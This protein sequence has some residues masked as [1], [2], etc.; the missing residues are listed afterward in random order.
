[1]KTYFNTTLALMLIFLTSNANAYEIS[2]VNEFSIFQYLEEVYEI[3]NPVVRLKKIKS[4]INKVEDF[5]LKIKILRKNA[6]YWSLNSEWKICY[7]AWYIAENQDFK[8]A[9]DLLL[10]IDNKNNLDDNCRIFLASMAR[11][12]NS[13]FV[14]SNNHLY[15]HLKHSPSFLLKTWN[16]FNENNVEEFIAKQWEELR[17][18]I[19]YFF[20]KNFN[21][22]KSSPL[23]SELIDKIKNKNSTDYF[24][25]KDKWNLMYLIWEKEYAK[26]IYENLWSN[27][28]DKYPISY[29]LAIFEID[30]CNKEKSD[31]YMKI[32]NE[33]YKWKSFIKSIIDKDYQ[34]RIAKCN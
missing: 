16:K 6:E 21:I 20:L 26:K 31:Y 34:N 11:S 1:M 19:D 29:W 10:S 33:L 32:S 28:K 25:M 22:V 18:L 3:E 27:H 17:Y 30:L 5:K 13:N 8:T 12:N 24:E 7:K 23:R 4:D 14:D 15:S 9:F 2:N